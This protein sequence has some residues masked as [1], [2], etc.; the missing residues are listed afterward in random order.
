VPVLRE[1]RAKGVS[2]LAEALEAKVKRRMLERTLLG[3]AHGA[4][5]K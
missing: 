5:E 3:I 1:Q 4:S 2:A